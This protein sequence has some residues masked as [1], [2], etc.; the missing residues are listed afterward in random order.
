VLPFHGA[1]RSGSG[2]KKTAIL[3]FK[4]TA[5]LDRLRF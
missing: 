3:G 4:K 5:I 2:F 1:E